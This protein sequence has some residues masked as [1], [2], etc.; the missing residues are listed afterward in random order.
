MPENELVD[1]KGV[2][3]YCTL[4]RIQAVFLFLESPRRNT[5][6]LRRKLSERSRAA[7]ALAFAQFS[8]LTSSP[9]EGRLVVVYI[10]VQYDNRQILDQHLMNAS[11]HHRR[12]QKRGMKKSEQE[13]QTRLDEIA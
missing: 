1:L 9:T 8:A 3:L 4:C 2:Q 11:L 12:P 7:V 5:Q 13:D 10:C 6:R